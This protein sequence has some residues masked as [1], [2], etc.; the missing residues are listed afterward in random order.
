MSLHKLLLM[1]LS[2][3]ITNKEIWRR[4]GQNSFGNDIGQRRWRWIAHTLRNDN[5]IITKIALYPQGTGKRGRLRATWTRTKDKDGERSEESWNDRKKLA[6]DR[7]GW[8]L[9]VWGLNPG[10]GSVR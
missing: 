5:T 8:R 9:F 10:A 2:D 6:Q 3:K 1:K 7:E 4:T